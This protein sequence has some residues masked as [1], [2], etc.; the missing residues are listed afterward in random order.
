[1]Y[2][3]SKIRDEM[4]NFFAP[5]PNLEKISGDIKTPNLISL[6]FFQKKFFW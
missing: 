3:Y 6:K 5:G 4:L 2:I 1:M